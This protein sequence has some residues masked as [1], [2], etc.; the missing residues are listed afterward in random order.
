MVKSAEDRPNNELTGPL[1]RP[2]A[3]R[4]LEPLLRP[5]M[6]AGRRLADMPDFARARSHGAR[7]LEQFPLRQLEAAEVQCASARICATSPPP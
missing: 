5:V 6:R 1:D 2:M 4:I 3:R 7:S